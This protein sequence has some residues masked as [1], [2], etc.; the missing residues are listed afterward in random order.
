VI[1]TWIVDPGHDV[2]P[3]VLREIERDPN[4]SA[5]IDIG[6]RWALSINEWYVATIRREDLPEGA[7]A[8]DALRLAI[9]DLARIRLG[10]AS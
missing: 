6:G 3:D 1:L 7:E 2:A 10:D 4:V 5:W 9:L 8:Q